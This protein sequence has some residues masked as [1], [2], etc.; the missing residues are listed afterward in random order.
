MNGLIGKK[1]GMTQVFSDEGN[2]VPVT[3][4]DVSSCEVVGKRTLEK[5]QYT[6]VVLGFKDA[7]EKLVDAFTREY[8]ATLLDRCGNSITETAKAAGLARN[9]VHR[10][11]NKFD[12]RGDD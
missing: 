2:A 4:I 6:A 9:Y 11:V 7:K 12:L 5:D 8:I 10:L 1:I 3:V